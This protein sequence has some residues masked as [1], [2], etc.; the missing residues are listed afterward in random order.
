M[1]ECRDAYLK[2]IVRAIFDGD[3]VYIVAS[4]LAAPCLD[5]VRAEYPKRYVPVG[6]AEQNLIA[7]ASGMALVGKKVI[8][9]TSNPFMVFRAFDQIRN[10]ACLMNLKVTLVGLGAGFSPPDYGFTHFILDDINLLMG[11][12]NLTIYNISDINLARYAA[13]KTP[14]LEA[15][16]YVR[17]DRLVNSEYD[18]TDADI[19]RGFR[20]LHRAAQTDVCVVATGIMSTECLDVLKAHDE[21]SARVTLIDLF[22][23]PFEAHA[24]VAELRKYRRVIT[25]EEM[26]LQGGMGSAVLE[27]LSDVDVQVPVRRMGVD[28]SR[29]LSPRYGSRDWH[30]KQFGLDKDSIAE[31]IS[32]ALK[33]AKE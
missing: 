23:F 3:D 14:A 20:F 2:E 22:A 32:A 13:Q 31:N 33:S 29:N 15:P 4:D 25:V 12:P 17:I 30:L 6:I 10:C 8:A 18:L 24:L 9:Y 7:V 19:Q 1:N 27:A 28:I 5:K 26:R 21:F 11:L 16:L